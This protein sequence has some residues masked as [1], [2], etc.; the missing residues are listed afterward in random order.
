MYFDYSS[1]FHQASKSLAGANGKPIDPDSSLWP[2]AWKTAHYK[3]YA[4]TP[5]IGLPRPQTPA[6]DYFG[7]IGTRRSRRD[8][9]SKPLDTDVLSTL[10][11]YSCGLLTDEKKGV[12]SRAQPT[13]GGLAPIEVYPLIFAGNDDIPSGVYHYNVKE[14]SLDVLWKRDFGAQDIS[15]LFC[16]PWV[17]KAS[18]AIILTAVFSRTQ[19]KYGQRGYRYILL[20]AGHIG[21]NIY[22]GAEALGLKC[23]AMGGTRDSNIE[24]LLDID[25]IAE[26][27]VYALVFG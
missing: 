17:E 12:L 7:L 26:S 4:R 27:V 19:V 24:T 14:H 25:G 8:F 21:E 10:L 11:R 5:Q 22:L 6:A 15:Q 16:Y 13:G 1:L 3:V 2:D 18:F 23:C 20:E 9:N